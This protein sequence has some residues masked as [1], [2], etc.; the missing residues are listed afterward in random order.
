MLYS[1]FSVGDFLTLTFNIDKCFTTTNVF[2]VV[3]NNALLF[4]CRVQSDEVPTRER[5][6]SDSLLEASGAIPGEGRNVISDTWRQVKD[7]AAVG[8][9][10][11]TPKRTI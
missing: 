11:I 9:A 3:D 8:L 4:L 6:W 1:N 10:T 5:T 2:L 7:R